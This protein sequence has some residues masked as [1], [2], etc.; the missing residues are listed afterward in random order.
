MIPYQ[1]IRSDRKTLQIKI[2][3]DGRLI[4]K[5]PHWASI[6]YIEEFIASKADW[7]EKHRAAIRPQQDMEPV[8][9]AEQLKQLAAAAK[10]DLPPR[11][12]H[13]ARIVGVTYNRISIRAQ[14]SRWG[15]CSAKG[16][17]N[18][19]CLLMLFPEDVRDYIVVHELCHRKQF[20]HSPLFWAEVEKIMPGYATQ[21]QWLK[22]HGGAYV[23][24][25]G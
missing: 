16:N 10:K 15:S 9:T 5:A 8:F 13:W 6:G 19:N 3:S 11:V 12:A 18:F 20:N 7:I 1:L 21:A 23:R 25:L 17:L 22:E 14:L 24:R 2:D 4:V